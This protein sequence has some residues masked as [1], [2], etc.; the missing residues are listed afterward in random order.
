MI[1]W[2]SVTALQCVFFIVARVLIISWK[3]VRTSFCIFR[4]FAEQRAAGQGNHQKLF[5]FSFFSWKWNSW[6]SNLY[7]CIK[8][9]VIRW[10]SVYFP[11]ID[12]L[13]VSIEP[14]N[15]IKVVTPVVGIDTAMKEVIQPKLF[16]SLS[17]V[18]FHFFV[19]WLKVFLA[20]SQQYLHCH[21][22][23]LI[24]ILIFLLIFVKYKMFSFW[25][26]QG[27]PNLGHL[28]IFCRI[29]YLK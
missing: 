11:E 2:M 5:S 8:S 10:F 18:F 23:E 25:E 6:S 15:K 16:R 29:K 21:I 4:H 22:W 28:S 19:S 12:F 26:F 9:Y 27:I 14:V 20:I 3:C 24:R 17:E 7:Y 13:N 1:E